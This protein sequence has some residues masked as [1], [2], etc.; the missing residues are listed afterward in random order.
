V[1]RSPTLQDAN[2]AG[3]VQLL[4]GDG[5]WMRYAWDNLKKP[6]FGWARTS[7]WKPRPIDKK[8]LLLQDLKLA[9]EAGIPV[10]HGALDAA[11][12]LLEE[13]P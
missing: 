8:T 13:A 9:R 11:I 7:D 3:D 10:S 5:D 6:N 4:D 1:H 2:E 12:E